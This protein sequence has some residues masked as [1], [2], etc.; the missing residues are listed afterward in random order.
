MFTSVSVFRALTKLQHSSWHTLRDTLKLLVATSIAFFILHGP[1]AILTISGCIESSVKAPGSVHFVFLWLANTNSCINMFICMGLNQN[2][3]EA[4]IQ[5]LHKP[6]SCW[7]IIRQCQIGGSDMCNHSAAG[8]IH[9]ELASMKSE[10]VT[11][12]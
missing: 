5:S 10:M 11:E 8:L 2:L 4:I 3:R 7:N 9:I 1:Y 12:L 6:F